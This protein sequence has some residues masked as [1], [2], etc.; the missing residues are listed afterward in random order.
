MKEMVLMMDAKDE[1]R[2]EGLEQGRME[3]EAERNALRDENERLKQEIE[4]LR[5][6][7]GAP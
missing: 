7:I 4:E 2:E 1:G 6:K 3:G 5:N